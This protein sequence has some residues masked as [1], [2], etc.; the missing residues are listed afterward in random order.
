M[1]INAGLSY[2]GV[3]DVRRV[4]LHALYRFII[5][6]IIFDAQM[7]NAIPWYL[8]MYIFVLIVNNGPQYMHSLYS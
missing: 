6:I 8:F 5:P 4:A 3:A 1:L 2:L 7:H